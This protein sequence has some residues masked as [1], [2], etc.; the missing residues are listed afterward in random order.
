MKFIFPQNYRLNTKILGIIEY[1]AAILDLIWG[2][3]VF[4]FINFFINNLSTKI[5]LFI[6]LVFPVVIFSIV[7]INGENLLHFIVYVM[8]YL[9]RPKIIL[10]EKDNKLK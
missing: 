6:I 8:R 9:Y 4:V 5:F 1:Q 3:C 10:Y 7:G 2:I